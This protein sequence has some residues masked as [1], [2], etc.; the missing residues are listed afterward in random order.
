MERLRNSG[1]LLH[2]SS[3]PSEFG[4]GDLGIE[5]YTFVDNLAQNGIRIWQILPLGP[6]GPGNSP[7]QA[8]S[9]YAG[10]PILISPEKLMEWGLLSTTDL[11][12][13]PSFCASKVN[14]DEVSA[15]KQ[16]IHLKAW[17]TFIIQAPNSLKK[18]YD[19]FLNEHNWWLSDY[20]L[21]AACKTKY[22]GEPWNKWPQEIIDRNHEVLEGLKCML[23]KEYEFERFQQF[24]F[25]RQWFQLKN[26]ANSQGIQIFGDIPLYVALDSSDVWAN[27]KMFLLDEIGMPTLV[28]GVPPDYFCEDGQLWG[29]PV[30]NWDELE[31][32]GFQWWIA[33]LYFNLHMFNIV[34]ID[35]F[36]GLES[37]WAVPADAETA[38]TG[39][40][41]PA[42]GFELLS[43]MQ[44]RQGKLPIIA[45]DLGI[46]TPEVEQLRDHFNLQGMK[47]LQFAFS[48]DATNEHL[49]HNI[50]YNTIA[51]TGTHDND[52]L[53]GWWNSIDNAE[54]KKAGEYI[55]GKAG[56]VRQ[57]LIEQV[58]SSSAETVIIPMQDILALGTE[59]RMNIPGTATGNWGW[60][61]QKRQL[62]KEHFLMIKQLNERYNR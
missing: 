51:Y 39:Q 16:K 20:A 26:F 43:I 24:L 58:W 40:W 12:G 3:L 41:L 15:W 33:R 18:E 42:K 17:Q 23:H 57:R 32:A 9:A 44:S 6:N 2:I 59:A 55:G 38:K 31:K 1:V 30:F 61:F 21:Y 36:R 25:F 11:A 52:T 46:I 56:N 28:G 48:S 10:D 50:S 4:V 27:Q 5:A 47:V 54:R 7:Y 22:E 35:H 19:A 37:F 34:R 49:P 45:E 60:R 13:K 29:N 62:K 14:F 8:Y 53:I